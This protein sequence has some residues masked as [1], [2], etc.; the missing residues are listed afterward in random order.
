MGIKMEEAVFCLNGQFLPAGSARVSVLDQGFL[1]GYGLFETIL[2]RGSL[3]LI[4]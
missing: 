2:V 1:S 4:I 3:Y